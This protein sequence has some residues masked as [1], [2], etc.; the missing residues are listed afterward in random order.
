[1]HT[2]HNFGLIWLIHNAAFSVQNNVWLIQTLWLWNVHNKT[3]FVLQ[4]K[5]ENNFHA[6]WNKFF[7]PFELLTTLTTEVLLGCPEGFFLEKIFYPFQ[8]LTFCRV[9]AFYFIF[10]A[11]K[12][13]NRVAFLQIEWRHLSLSI[14][15][16][17]K[18]NLSNVFFAS[19]IIFT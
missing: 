9:C 16:L 4:M 14:D 12:I 1:M 17:D 5:L 2:E 18:G 11:F 3:Y 6:F 19:V 7:T 15:N 13:V 8:L 10:F